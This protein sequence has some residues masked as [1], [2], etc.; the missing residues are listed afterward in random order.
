MSKKGDDFYCITAMM[1]SDNDIV[2][3]YIDMIASQGL[4]TDGILYFDDLYL[5]LVV[6]PNGEIM[7]DD[8]D[9]LEEALRQ[10]DI[11]QAQFD[12]AMNT[13][14]TLKADC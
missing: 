9:E 12:L 5:D 14:D 2:V 8:L 4:D 11:T 6:Y 13:A 10:S 7:V 1:N 3:W